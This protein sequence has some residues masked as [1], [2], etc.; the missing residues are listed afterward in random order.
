MQIL[1][2][3]SSLLPAEKLHLFVMKLSASFL[4]SVLGD[5]VE[6]KFVDRH[7]FVRGLLRRS[8]VSTQPQHGHLCLWF[9]SQCFKN[10]FLLSSH[11]LF[12][13]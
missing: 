7:H 1:S 3:L 6:E 4:T 8:P 9:V 12:W 13:N 10:G 2:S 11:F 5:D